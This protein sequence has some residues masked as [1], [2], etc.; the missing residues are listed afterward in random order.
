MEKEQNQ[1][2]NDAIEFSHYKN[3]AKA[4]LTLY[5]TEIDKLFKKGREIEN[6]NNWVRP[7]SFQSFL[8]K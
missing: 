2:A 8:L 4:Q 6:E 3:E 7:T 5:E 1:R